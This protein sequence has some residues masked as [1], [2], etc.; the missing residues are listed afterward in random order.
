MSENEI[1]RIIVDVAFKIHT[2]LGPGLLESVYESAFSYELT[3]RG[4]KVLRQ[5][6]IPIV[7]E[8][9]RLE[10]GFRADLI[11]EDKVIVEIKSVEQIAAVHKKQLLTYLRLADKRLGLLINFGE[12]LIKGV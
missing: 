9:I 8:S 10:E 3:K 2:T 4:L 6:G 11:V 7:Y 5:V 12:T 1:A